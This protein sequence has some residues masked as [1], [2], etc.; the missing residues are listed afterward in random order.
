MGGD[1]GEREDHLVCVSENG[2]DGVGAHLQC[3]VM[4][5]CDDLQC[6]VEARLHRLLP[7]HF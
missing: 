6:G 3:G 4:V 1:G 2:G 5:V 7:L